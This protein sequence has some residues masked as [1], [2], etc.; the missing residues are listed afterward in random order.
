M[1]KKVDGFTEIKARRVISI[2]GQTDTQ[3]PD[4]GAEVFVIGPESHLFTTWL[5]RC[6]CVKADS[7]QQADF[8]LF[9]GG[10][11]DVDPRLYGGERYQNTWVKTE[12][13]DQYLTAFYEC[14]YSGIPMVGVCLGA[15]FLHVMNGGRMYQSVDGH[16]GDH[17]IMVWGTGEIIKKAS[18]LH[19]Q[20]CE[21]N[22]ENGMEILASASESSF[23][24]DANCKLIDRAAS[25]CAMAEEDVEAFVYRSTGVI[26]FQGHPEYF[27]YDEYSSWCAS[28]IAE[29]LCSDSIEVFEG[30][31][32]LNDEI[33]DHREYDVP[34]TVI[35]YH[36]EKEL[37]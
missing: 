32:R 12:L 3:M 11:P 2:K 16:N 7:I 14:V 30:K 13:M 4:I 20:A 37:S 23:R 21:P 29:F 27:G 33:L 6:G 26:G 9:S 8:V 5:A 28:Q 36:V 34:S 18:S 19:K 10:S 24:I 22:D 31:L 17:P 25:P 1:T 15:Q 35:D